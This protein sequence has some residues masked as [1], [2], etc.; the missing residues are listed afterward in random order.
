MAW[1][2]YKEI[3][4]NLDSEFYKILS[5][6]S[7]YRTKLVDIDINSLPFGWVLGLKYLIDIKEIEEKRV[8]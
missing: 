2:T 7:W 4:S 1:G 8:I 6:Y 3:Y 5:I